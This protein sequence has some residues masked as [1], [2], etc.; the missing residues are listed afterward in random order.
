MFNK[1]VLK[2]SV[3][4]GLN[5]PFLPGNV[6]K[7]VRGFAP[8]LFQ[9]LS[10]R[11]VPFNPQSQRF[12]DRFL[13][14]K[15]GRTS[16]QILGLG[17]K[18]TSLISGSSGFLGSASAVAAPSGTAAAGSVVGGATAAAG[19]ASADASTAAEATAAAGTASGL[20]Q[21]RSLL[22]LRTGS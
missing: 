22:G 1:S 9:W 13:R 16:G 10:G 19:T 5:G 4:G 21:L 11:G 15:K 12:Q 20:E 14:N 8:H 3:L 2:S 6:S 7:K 18:M 17:S